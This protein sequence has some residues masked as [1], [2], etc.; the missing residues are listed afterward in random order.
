MCGQ[1]TLK[2]LSKIRGPF[3]TLTLFTLPFSSQDNDLVFAV[4]CDHVGVDVV[5]MTKVDQAVCG[6]VSASSPLIRVWVPYA[7]AD[8]FHELGIDQKI[9]HFV[10]DAEGKMIWVVSITGLVV[11][12]IAP[13]YAEQQPRH[14]TV[15][16]VGFKH[17]VSEMPPSNYR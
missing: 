7:F 4:A 16:P 5:F 17:D 3:L 15:G 12:I 8:H 1:N 11:I 14:G 6:T 10:E 13:V 2:R 9:H